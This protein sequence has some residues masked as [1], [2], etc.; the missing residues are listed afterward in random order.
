MSKAQRKEEQEASA[1]ST[2]QI[3]NIP[4]TSLSQKNPESEN[5]D[6][7]AMNA[8]NLQLE[9]QQLR[10]EIEQLQQSADKQDLQGEYERHL[11][12]QILEHAAGR[13]FATLDN[14]SHQH[15][16]LSYF[17]G[18]LFLVAKRPEGGMYCLLGDFTG[19]GLAAAIGSMPVSEIFFSMAAKSLSVG[20]IVTEMNTAMHR[21]L[22]DSMFFAACLIELDGQ[23]GRANLW[24]G[25][26]SDVLLHDKGKGSVRRISSQH[27]P[28][29]IADEESFDASYSRLYCRQGDSFFVYSD[30]L[31]E[32]RD[33]Q[34]VEYGDER[35][36]NVFGENLINPIPAVLQS[37]DE[38]IGES[39]PND[40]ITVAHI[41]CK[42]C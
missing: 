21:L 41:V 17:D 32:G 11:V 23:G 38:F 34:G 9:N 24:S 25:G 26:M 39:A 19:H 18:D 20:A 27:M 8:V 6:G 10:H 30:G 33:A 3:E 4:V 16:P 14:V 37:F 7:K 13:N 40:D 28:L 36:E 1:G 29:G 31:I 42:P 2:V 22:P 12:K 35:L 15:R 5:K